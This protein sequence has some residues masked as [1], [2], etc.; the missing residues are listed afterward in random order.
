MTLFD[1]IK[2]GSRVTIVNRFGQQ[3]AGRCVMKFPTHAVL[4]LGGAHGTPGIATAENVVKVSA[5]KQP[6]YL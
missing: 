5:A 2:P 4:N 3:Q 1:S 6:T